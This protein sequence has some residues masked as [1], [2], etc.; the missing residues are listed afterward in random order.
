MRIPPSSRPTTDPHVL[1]LTSSLLL[2]MSHEAK[3]DVDETSFPFPSTE[4]DL[5]RRSWDPPEMVV[6]V[7]GTRKGSDGKSMVVL[8]GRRLIQYACSQNR[9]DDNLREGGVYNT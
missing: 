1:S 3:V 9:D 5:L 2:W 4:F 6:K 8:F 7:R